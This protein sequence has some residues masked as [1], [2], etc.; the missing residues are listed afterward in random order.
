MPVSNSFK[1]LEI[2]DSDVVGKIGEATPVEVFDEV[3]DEVVDD[4][5]EVVV[6]RCKASK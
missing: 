1:E 2:S 4:V 6:A 3:F 5:V